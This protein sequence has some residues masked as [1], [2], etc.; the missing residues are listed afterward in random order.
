[1]EQLPVPV[2]SWIDGLQW[3]IKVIV[4]GH[5]LAYISPRGIWFHSFIQYVIYHSGLLLAP[6]HSL[7]GKSWSTYFTLLL[8]WL[9][10][11]IMSSLKMSS[12]PRP[13]PEALRYPYCTRKCQGGEMAEK[14][15]PTFS[16]CPTLFETS[17]WRGEERRAN[18]FPP[19]VWKKQKSSD[20]DFLKNVFL[21]WPFPTSYK[22]RKIP[23]NTLLTL[24][25]MLFSF[26]S[27]DATCLRTVVSM[28]CTKAAS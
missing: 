23:F 24:Q 15:S 2:G 5:F 18:L 22:P 3:A 21:F 14:L 9:L 6:D 25:E 1:M 20:K 28:S 13:S 27:D 11:R 4:S 10:P 19:V 17:D 12:S 26:S 7:T 16:L 8:N